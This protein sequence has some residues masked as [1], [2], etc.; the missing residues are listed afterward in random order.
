M[1]AFS[2]HFFLSRSVFVTRYQL[3]IELSIDWR[4]DSILF[5]HNPGPN[6]SSSLDEVRNATKTHVRAVYVL[7]E[8]AP[9]YEAEDLSNTLQYSAQTNGL[10]QHAYTDYVYLLG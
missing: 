2:C 1:F 9:A 3:S 5:V 6:N 8:T 7:V 10:I 4:I